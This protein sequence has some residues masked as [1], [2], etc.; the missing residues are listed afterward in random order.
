MQK[1][2]SSR[3]F[4]FVKLITC[5]L[6]PLTALCLFGG[7][8]D[9][10]AQEKRVRELVLDDCTEEGRVAADSLFVETQ[11]KEQAGDREIDRV[12]VPVQSAHSGP[13]TSRVAALPKGRLLF[14]ANSVVLTARNRKA[15][16]CAAAWLRG[17]VGTQRIA[18]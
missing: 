14:A 10:S 17:C 7:G 12:G 4:I 13:E 9:L 11:S 18:C 3:G 8:S 16:E 2:T 5:M 1:D 6:T 15:L